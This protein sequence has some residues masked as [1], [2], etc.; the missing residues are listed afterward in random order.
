MIAIDCLP[1]LR[2]FLIQAAAPPLDLKASTAGNLAS[3]A[4]PINIR[5]A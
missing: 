3:P 4:S 5:N 1:W 2:A